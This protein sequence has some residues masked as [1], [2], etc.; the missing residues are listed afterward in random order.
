[1]PS[2]RPISEL[3]NNANEISDF[4]RSNRE[5]VFI[6]RNGSGDMV[7]MSMEEYERLGARLELYVKLAEAETEVAR[8]ESGADFEVFAQKLR[9]NVHGTL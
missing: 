9:N 3:R 5:P 6:T 8:G 1:M 2:I 7:V 4:C